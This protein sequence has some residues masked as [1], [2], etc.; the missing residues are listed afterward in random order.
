[1]TP[2]GAVQLVVPAVENVAVAAYAGVGEKVETKRLKPKKRGTPM[3]IA[4]VE[5]VERVEIDIVGALMRLLN[6]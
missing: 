6:Y 3:R 5:R 4:R 1:V 2:A